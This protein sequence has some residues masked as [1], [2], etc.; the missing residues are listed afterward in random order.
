[1]NLSISIGEPKVKNTN[2][3]DKL[4]LAQRVILLLWDKLIDQVKFMIIDLS[5]NVQNRFFFD[6]ISHKILV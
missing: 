5:Q 4:I 1:M 6:S 3:I 2:L